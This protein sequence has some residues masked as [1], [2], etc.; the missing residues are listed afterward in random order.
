MNF[1]DER[2]VRVYTKDTP[3]WRLLPWEGRALLPLLLRAVDRAGVID[4][5]DEVNEGLAAAVGLPVEVVAVG[6]PAL[7][8]RGTVV[9]HADGMLALPKFIEAQEAKQSDKQRQKESRLRRAEIGAI[10]NRDEPSQNV[11]DCHETIQNVTTGHTASQP[12]TSGHSVLS[13]AVPNCAVPSKSNYDVPLAA[14]TLGTAPEVVRPLVLP[15]VEATPP[16][17]GPNPATAIGRVWVNYLAVIHPKNAHPPKWTEDRRRLIERALALYSEADLSRTF[18][19]YSKS[20]HHNGQN[21]R[22]KKYL[23]IDLLL[24]KAKN[25]EDGWTYLETVA[26]PKMKM[27]YDPATDD[28]AVGST[29]IGFGSGR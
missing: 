28:N 24:R 26:S 1:S 10:T 21:D 17:A 14:D 22:G 2:Y 25:I 4:L 3:T 15:A 19:G 23:D 11:T 29:T 18:D 13:R 9:L 5:G 8:K 20:G 27:T 6:L 7:V 12:V 16:P